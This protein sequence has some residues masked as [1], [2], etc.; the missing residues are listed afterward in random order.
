MIQSIILSLHDIGYHLYWHRLCIDGVPIV[1][2]KLYREHPGIDTWLPCD[3]FDLV[4]G[5]R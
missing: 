1:P 2:W 3:R 5:T 4:T